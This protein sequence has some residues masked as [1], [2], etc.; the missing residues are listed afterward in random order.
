[1]NFP[2]LPTCGAGGEAA[3]RPEEVLRLEVHVWGSGSC[4]A[5]PE[6]PGDVRGGVGGRQHLARCS[7]LDWRLVDSDVP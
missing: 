7:A 6:G 3:S 5:S 1:M 4:L 2:A